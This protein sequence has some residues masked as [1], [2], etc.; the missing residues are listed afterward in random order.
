LSAP[1]RVSLAQSVTRRVPSYDYQM[2]R[3]IR[4][5]IAVLEVLLAIRFFLHLLGASSDAAFTVFVY[6]VTYPFLIPFLRIFANPSQGPFVLD[7]SA[8]VALIVYP[9]LG[10]GLG[11]LIRIK[12]ARRDPWD[13]SR[14]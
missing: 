11:G 3:V 9:L 14:G 2:V 5:V 1:E 12:T 7:T 4:Y 10:W 13:D 8:L 6:A